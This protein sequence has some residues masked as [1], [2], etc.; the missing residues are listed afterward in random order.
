M[1]EEEADPTVC[2]AGVPGEDVTQASQQAGLLALG[3]VQ[4]VPHL[5]RV[6]LRDVAGRP[7]EHPTLSGGRHL[8]GRHTGAGRQYCAAA[9]CFPSK[10]FLNIPAVPGP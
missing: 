6:V 7:V 1:C 4:V 3:R 9:G 2:S 8:S 10:T 5:H